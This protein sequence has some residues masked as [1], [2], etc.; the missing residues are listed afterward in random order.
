MLVV[1]LNCKI[2]GVVLVAALLAGGSLHA[3]TLTV[4]NLNDTGADSLRQSCADASSG[5][6]I[7]F[8][9]ALAGTITFAG[10]IGIGSK[11]LTI[12][13][14]VNAS[15]RPAITL[16]G[17]D[18]S[19]LF[20]G[21]AGLTV[22]NLRFISGNPGGLPG[23]AIDGG[24]VSATNCVFEGNEGAGGGAIRTSTA[25]SMLTLMNCTFHDNLSTGVGGAVTHSGDG[26]I[27]GCTFSANTGESGG[28]AHFF[29]GSGTRVVDLA[30]CTFSGNL[31]THASVG[32]GAILVAASGDGSMQVDARSCTF[33]DNTATAANAGQCI[34]LQADTVTV[35]Q[36]ATARFRT[37]NSILADTVSEPMFITGSSGPGAPLTQ[38][39]SLG[40]NL[41]SDAQGWLN[42]TGDQPST[43]P[44]LFALAENGGLT[45]THAL[46]SGSPALNTGTATGVPTTDQRGLP[47]DATPDIGAFEAQPGGGGGGNGDDD[48]DDGGCVAG[49]AAAI[50]PAWIAVLALWRRRKRQ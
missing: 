36:G 34:R 12:T 17:N 16:S 30:N 13:G 26:A 29:A 37:T 39:T 27:S 2:L 14:N 1:N 23:G 18:A 44:M 10:H 32:G 22:S 42:Q 24:T 48:G 3:A 28:A 49:V 15:G 40:H 5:D 6:T 20:Q 19:R 43:N 38:E 50:A 4:L 46:Q 45:R 47:R 25:G 9:A 8:E 33:S 35:P 41:C 11:N 31:A 21:T 7:V